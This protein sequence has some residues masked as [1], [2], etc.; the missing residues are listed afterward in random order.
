MK[1]RLPKE[2]KAKNR[3]QTTQTR[4][5]QKKN[6]TQPSP[7]IK[8]ISKNIFKAITLMLQSTKRVESGWSRLSKR[9]LMK[10]KL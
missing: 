4:K 2:L 3:H 1:K 10:A 6:F 7:A 8:L 5:A 9:W